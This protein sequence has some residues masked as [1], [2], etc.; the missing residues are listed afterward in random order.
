VAGT[1]DLVGL[2]GEIGS[3]RRVEGVAVVEIGDRL[4]DRAQHGVRARV[5]GIDP[6]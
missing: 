5:H 3:K 4:D 6:V 2:G 1:G